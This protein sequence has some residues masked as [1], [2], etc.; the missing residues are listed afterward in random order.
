[1]GVMLFSAPSISGQSSKK[2]AEKKISKV[3][4][5][6]YFIADGMSDPVVEKEESYDENGNLIEFKEYN[7]VGKVKTWEKFK[8]NENNDEVEVQ[9]LDEKGRQEERVEYSYDGNFVIEKRYF[10]NKD[11]LVKRKEYKYEYRN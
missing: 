7:K 3:T 5:Y 2:I 10:D 4:V 8:Y 1:L 9:V 11:R 6:E